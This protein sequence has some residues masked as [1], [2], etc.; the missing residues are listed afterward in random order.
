MFGF[1]YDYERDT[2]VPIYSGMFGTSVENVGDDKELDDHACYLR[3][4][5][6]CFVSGNCN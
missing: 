5:V 4:C 6:Y 2:D 1:S 3:V